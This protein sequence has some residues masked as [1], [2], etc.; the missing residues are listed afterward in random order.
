[1]CISLRRAVSASTLVLIL[2]SLGFCQGAP[3]NGIAVASNGSLVTLEQIEADQ[4]SIQ[5]LADLDEESK[6]RIIDLY[7][8]ATERIKKA[9]E[10]RVS[11]Q[12]YRAAAE[13]A[14]E[15]AKV[16]Q[17]ELESLQRQAEPD[18]LT[19]KSL[20][21][22]QQQ[23]TNHELQL[24]EW[25]ANHARI[26]KELNARTQRR[27]EI[28]ELMN[29][30]AQRLADIDHQLTAA[31]PPTEMGPLSAAK[32]TELTATRQMIELESPALRNELAMYEAE[33]A[34]ELSRL[35]RDLRLQTIA[36][37]DKS[38]ESLTTAVQTMRA[39]MATEAAAEAQQAAR[40]VLPV[41]KPFAKR[42]EELAEA[43]RALTTKL[44]AKE[45]K[46][47]AALKQLDELKQQIAQAEN[48]VEAVGLTA[49][50]GAM[51]RS[52]QNSLPDTRKLQLEIR[53]QRPLI[54]DT[55]LAKLQREEERNQ[56]SDSD[57]IVDELV[58]QAG[59]P[60]E[61]NV[62]RNAA[63]E[64][65]SQ[66]REYLN[67]LIASHGLYFD[68]L[69]ELSTRREQIV[70]LTKRYSNYIKE[71][72]LW[73]RSGKTLGADIWVAEDVENARLL[74]RPLVEFDAVEPS[75]WL[76]VGRAV[77]RDVRTN[78]LA[79]VGA[80]VLFVFFLM[81]GER[82]RRRIEH[83]G[84]LAEKPG[85]C[86]FGLTPRAIL[87]TVAISSVWP[88][89]LLFL[90][91]RIWQLGTVEALAAAIGTGLMVVVW[92]F[93]PLEILRQVCRPKGLA[94]SHFG[95]SVAGRQLFRRNLRNLNFVGAPLIFV[96]ALLSASHT[97]YGSD[98]VERLCFIG[99]MA[100]WSAFLGRVLHPTRGVLREYIA[101]HTGGWTDRLKYVW[102][103]LI[104]IFPLILAVLAFVG[105]Y[106]T[107][108]QLAW[109]LHLT[110][111]LVLLLAIGAAF[112]LRSLLLKRRQL[113]MEQARQ[114]RRAMAEQGLAGQTGEGDATGIVTPANS[115]EELATHSAQTRRL[116]RVVFL[117]AVLIGAWFIWNDVLPALRHLERWPL[118]TTMVEVAEPGGSL[119]MPGEVVMREVNKPITVVHLLFA[120][121]VAA[122]AL[123][124]SRN[125][126][127]LLEITVLQKLPLEPS[128]RYAITTLASYAIVVVGVIVM[129]QSLGLRWAQIQWLVT[130]LT[131]GLAF[132]L[133]EMFANFVAGIIILFEQPVRVGDV[134]TVSD[135]TG[136]VSRVRI[137]ATTITNWDRKDFIVPNKEFI[138][139]RILNWTLSDQVNRVVINVGVA[140]GTDTDETRSLLLEVANAHP[141]ILEDPA[142]VATFEGFGDSTLNFVLR[143][144][145]PTLDNRLA[146]I[147]E[148]HAEIDRRFAQ[149]GIEI[150]FPQRDLRI[151]SLPAAVVEEMSSRQTA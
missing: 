102:Y 94:E 70:N 109:K 23:L 127:G 136:V 104:V 126:P 55:Q 11:A 85:C 139:G 125:L 151:R 143:A 20:P 73:I 46:N 76:A 40:S 84:E 121:L 7:R 42:N 110:I 68:T 146:V 33:E 28:R 92:V 8:Q 50:V 89:L 35:Q 133:Q 14:V 27:K 12:Q 67:N 10:F 26:E 72:I 137:R 53:E 95:W 57:R 17:A 90:G 19:A 36:R 49:A 124:A 130:A 88:G 44:E 38:L 63:K 140:Y 131:F 16:V 129:F 52:Q 87:L 142:A 108:Q 30:A 111:A 138:T 80:G 54:D 77:V 145:L 118:W 71:R 105:Y 115:V 32:R 34:A 29:S 132:G 64:I 128:V 81:M 37:G 112:V 119:L 120:I 45:K 65:L 103:F 86:D 114:R 91:W 47:K 113:Y 117:V 122:I 147:H 69:I 150:A 13:E 123:T 66:Q 106:Y 4:K 1:M 25:K 141:K 135:V 134:V 144:Y 97:E 149:A 22:L 62:L 83:L 100:T 2:T 82:C 56:L 41:L 98:T 60:Q 61:N 15:K 59:T 116:I 9:D 58:R 101:R 43:V 24:N 39:R 6:K 99:V 5:E 96:T 51:L 79:Y 48:R 31:G 21:E 78:P 74:E 107:A 75:K 148:L 93:F 3:Q 18:P